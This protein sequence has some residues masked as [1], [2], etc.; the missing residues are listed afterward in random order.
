MKRVAALAALAFGLLLLG[1]APARADVSVSLSFFHRE[2][3]P[4]GRWVAAT[5]YGDVWVPTAAA[6]WQPYANGHWLYT[7][8]GWTWISADRWGG[9]PYHYGTWA[10]VSP[11][12]WVWVPGFVW[13]PAWV[14]WCYSDDYVGWA[15]LPPSLH[16]TVSGYVGPAVVVRRTAYVFVPASRLVG[17]NAAAVRVSPARNAT[18]VEHGRKVTG[19]SVTS[20]YVTNTGPPVRHIER[21]SGVRIAKTTARRAHVRPVPAQKWSTARSGNL[22]VAADR[23][24]RP[25]AQA[26]SHESHHAAA[27]HQ[28]HEAVRPPERTADTRAG[29]VPAEKTHENGHT[30]EARSHRAA[31]PNPK[32][33]V[34]KQPAGRGKPETAEIHGHPV[35]PEHPAHPKSGHA[36]KPPERATQHEHHKPPSESHGGRS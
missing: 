21:A 9:D 4:Y 5:P 33:Q 10:F 22:A 18:L 14:T 11:W 32:S 17:V 24:E 13:A 25:P 8:Y 3:A 35:S 2:L 19:F 12:G 20:G 36:A 26:K 27:S 15:P 16:I 23:E 31:E 29:A 6:G 30:R 34:E 7:D 28:R 1:P